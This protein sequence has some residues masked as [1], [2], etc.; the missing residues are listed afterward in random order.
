MLLLLCVDD[1]RDSPV[2]KAQLFKAL[3]CCSDASLTPVQVTFIAS[4]IW[5]VFQSVELLCL[6]EVKLV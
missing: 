3:T 6:S 4:R 2:V 1:S 5:G